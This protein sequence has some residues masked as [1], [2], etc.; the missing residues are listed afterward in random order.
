MKNKK[1]LEEEKNFG[2]PNKKKSKDWIIEYKW[3]SI[4]D[5]NKYPKFFFGSEDYSDKW[6]S[7]SYNNKFVSLKSAMQSVEK[8]MKVAR[9]YHKNDIMRGFYDDKFGKLY[10]VRNLKTGE[11][12]ELSNTEHN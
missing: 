12:H 10:R 2:K 11:I 8:F 6:R 1:Y 9:S 4:E 3:R 7:L 5:Y